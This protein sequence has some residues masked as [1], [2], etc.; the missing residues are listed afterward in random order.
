MEHIPDLADAL[1]C[2]RD[3]EIIVLGDINTNI[4]AQ[5]P[6]SQQVAKMLTEFRLVDLQHHLGSDGGSNTG[7]V[8]SYAARQIVAENM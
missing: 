4:Q 7:N 1:T 5:N 6:C 3:Q 8:V 2:L